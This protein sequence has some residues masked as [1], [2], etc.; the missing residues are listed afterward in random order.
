MNVIDPV[1]A[2]PP[3]EPFATAGRCLNCAAPLAGDYCSACGQKS[4]L[5]RTLRSFFAD[6]LAGTLNFEGRLWQTL[7]LLVWRPGELTR[8]YVD[9]QRAR[10][11][12]PIGLYL[13]TVFLMFAVLNFSGT[14]G[15]LTIGQGVNEAIGNDQQQLRKLQEQRDALQRQGKDVAKVD[16]QIAE[17]VKSVQSLQ[18]VRDGKF[19]TSLDDSKQSP[20][21][22]KQTVQ[23]VATN[24]RE[25]SAHVQDAASKYSW[26]LIPLSVPVLWLLFPLRRRHLYDH[27][28]F[29]TY[30][31]SFMMFLIIVGGLLVMAGLSNWAPFLALI[32][33][34]HMY[35][36][37]KGA[38]GLTWYGA[39]ARTTMLLFGAITVLVMWFITVA[40][41]GVVG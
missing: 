20:E 21:W 35:R 27:T 38:Y 40:A 22:L 29:V 30:S 10:F 23:K 31:L 32:P 34:I 6:F 16:G 17:T 25:A 36:Q 19:E 41:L 24:P 26:L 28:V 4:K 12:S 3:V 15:D 7:P 18:N 13:F 9:G 14:L 33:P 11:V 39:L 2:E 37:M 5:P 1:S 8:R